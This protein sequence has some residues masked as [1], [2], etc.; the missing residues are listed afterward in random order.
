MDD[1]RL[2]LLE[3]VQDKGLVIGVKVIN[4]VLYLFFQCNMLLLSKALLLP[5]VELLDV[6][7]VIGEDTFSDVLRDAL[8][9]DHTVTVL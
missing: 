4:I 1:G 6:S 8:I 5:V 3:V 7:H 2:L 9:V